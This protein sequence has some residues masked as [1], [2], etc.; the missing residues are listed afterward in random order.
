MHHFPH[1]EE[2]E[3]ICHVRIFHNTK[4]VVVG[5]A[6]FLLCCQILK[7]I[8]KNISL[9][10][11]LTGIMRNTCSRCGP[12]SRCMVHVIRVKSG[13]FDLLHGH[14]SGELI[15][16]RTDH[17]QMCQFVRTRMLY[18]MSEIIRKCL[19]YMFFS[20]FVT[21]VLPTKFYSNHCTNFLKIKEIQK[22]I[23]RFSVYSPSH[24]YYAFTRP[25]YNNTH[26]KKGCCTQ[27]PIQQ[28]LLCSNSLKNF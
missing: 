27:P 21:N 23:K 19:F 5:C 18:I 13:F 3:R 12:Q 28:S 25:H 7:Q 10:L 8:R 1:S 14:V 20:G 15:D 24:Y 6:C 16:D 11:V 22:M 17:F 2:P 4:Q 9:G 26:Y